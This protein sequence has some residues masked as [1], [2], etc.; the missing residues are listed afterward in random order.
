MFRWQRCSLL[1]HSTPAAFELDDVAQHEQ[2]LLGAEVVVPGRSRASLSCGRPS[3][4]RDALNTAVTP[5][6]PR[7]DRTDDR[8]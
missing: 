2:L 3:A 1:E 7:P 8:R 6:G 5:G 4:G